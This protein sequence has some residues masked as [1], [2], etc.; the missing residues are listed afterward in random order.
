MV[1]ALINR[2]KSKQKYCDSQEKKPQ[3]YIRGGYFIQRL[4][5]R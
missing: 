3:Y 5:S 1:F 2:S 4:L